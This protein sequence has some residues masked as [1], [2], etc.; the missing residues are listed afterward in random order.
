[1]NKNKKKKYYKKS[2]MLVID[3]LRYDTVNNSFL[4]PTLSQLI[5]NGIYKKVIA[6]A[7]STQFVLPSLFS[8]TYPLDNGG[9]NFGIRDRKSSYVESIKRKYKRKIIMISSCNQMGIGTSYDRGFD[10]ILTTFDF[11][12]L[13]EQ[14]INRTLLYEVN[15]YFNKKISKNKIIKILQKE[16]AITL[17]QLDK[18]YK[19][20]DQTLWPKK[21]RKIN[22]F[23]YENSKLEK[24]ILFHSPEIIINKI[25]NIPG[26]VYWLTLGKTNYVSFNYFWTR[27]KTGI[28]W[29][30]GK[31]VTKQ[32][33]WPF[34][35]LS[36]YQV[37]FG[38]I[39][40]KILD[41]ISK[42][43]N[44]EW[45]IHMHI[46]DLHDSRSINRF[47][48]LLSRFRFLFK[49]FIARIS[50]NTNQRFTYVSSLMY[51]DKCI[52]T[53]L[54]HLQKENIL[55]DTLLLITADHACYYPESPRKK[56]PRMGE[57]GYYEDLDIPL[58]LLHKH[59]KKIERN[60]CDSMG[61][62]A[63]FLEILNVPLD[64][65]YKGQSIFK[66]GKKFV[67]SE[68]AGTGNADL[69][70]KDLFFAITTNEY[71]LMLVLNSKKLTVIK[72]FNISE[73]PKE[74]NNL[75]P[76]G[77]N[78]THTKIVE[79]L[80]TI[81]YEERKNIFDLRGIKNLESCYNVK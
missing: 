17:E 65:S 2:I 27:L 32:R 69:K 10:E 72:F 37:L 55:K 47:F 78:P 5:K 77:K 1:V 36:H 59:N 11:R 45:H 6:N 62:T 44:E 39:L 70:R 49:W 56:P 71:K 61:V 66:K 23:V 7:C 43:K 48:H 16:F 42:I 8:L 80:V 34:L 64:K 40:K 68:N 57:R 22:K 51:I 67:I 74:K 18:Y 12:L 35:I 3:A 41:K 14:K 24:K 81:V 79:K 25:K 60:I 30:T 31:I 9:Y 54:N 4:Y 50:G 13:I 29:R 58:I 46:M 38:E 53:F 28:A 76:L 63:T 75:L 21:L 26:G 52:K 73:D 33:L 20:Y 19:Q 15:L